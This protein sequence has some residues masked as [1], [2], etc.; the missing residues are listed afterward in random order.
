MH[1]PTLALETVP[2]DYP[3]NWDA[4]EQLQRALTNIGRHMDR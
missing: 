4:V 2:L 1:V 3:L